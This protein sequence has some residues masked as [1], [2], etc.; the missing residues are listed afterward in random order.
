MLLVWGGGR[1]M[2]AALVASNRYLQEIHHP[3]ARRLRKERRS[4]ASDLPR[5]GGDEAILLRH[6]AGYDT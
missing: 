1:Q 2:M 5:N 3:D 4:C 6:V